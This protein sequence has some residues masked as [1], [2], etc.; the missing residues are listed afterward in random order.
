MTTFSNHPPI[1]FEGSE[2]MASARRDGGVYDG[3]GYNT[4]KVYEGKRLHLVHFAS[5]GCEYNNHT[6]HTSEHLGSFSDKP[7]LIEHLL[8]ESPSWW[9][10][11]LLEE[12]GYVG[13][14][15]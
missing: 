6:D 5:S 7:K 1:N 10:D 14:E 2:K 3:I 12:L 13:V 9:A 8:T 11:E 15:A 4:Y